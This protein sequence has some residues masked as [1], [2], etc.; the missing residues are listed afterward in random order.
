MDTTRIETI[1]TTTYGHFATYKATTAPGGITDGKY[2]FKVVL[3]G[4]TYYS[5]PFCVDSRLSNMY[6][7]AIDYTIQQ[8]APDVYILSLN[9]NTT[10]THGRRT[11][12]FE[13]AGDTINRTVWQSPGLS[14][15]TLTEDDGT[16]SVSTIVTFTHE[17]D[18]GS[19]VQTWVLAFDSSDL[20]GTITFTLLEEAY[21]IPTDSYYLLTF[22]NAND[23]TSMNLY[24]QDGY[25]QKLFIK[26]FARVPQVVN[27]ERYQNNGIGTPYFNSQTIS[28]RVLLD[29]IGVP[30]YLQSVLTGLQNHSTITLYNTTTGSSQDL[31]TA[32]PRFEF[33]PVDGD[34]ILKGTLSFEQNRAFVACEDNMEVCS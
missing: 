30:D 27:E 9:F 3:D 11:I 10:I 20:A 13:Q 31:S 23:I 4:T 1:C 2:Q 33:T 25:S 14:T 24:Y 8:D 19:W 17:F 5:H 16:G 6:E 7:K 32:R 29:F 22:R 15:L 21:N 18:G 34:V 28:E 12:T 26:A